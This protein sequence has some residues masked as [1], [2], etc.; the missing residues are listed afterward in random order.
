MSNLLKADLFRVLKSKLTIVMACLCVGFPLLTCLLYFGIDLLAGFLG[1][2]AL[3]GEMFN[4]KLIIAGS[5]SLSNNLG[6]V[7]PIFSSLFICQD[8]SNGT[9]RNKIIIGENRKKIYL[10]HLVTTV[11]FNVAASIVYLIFNVVFSSLFFGYGSAIDG[12]EILYLF[13]FFIT[14]IFTF[15][16]IATVSA[17]FA[18]TLRSVAPTIIFT[19]LVGMGLSVI[20]SLVQLLNIEKVKYIMYLIPT[21]SNTVY[22]STMSLF[23][24]LPSGAALF[25]EGVLSYIIF[26]GLNTL[27]GI[28]IFKKKDLK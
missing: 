8:I 4:G 12:S 13:Y 28:L 20:L 14:G 18:M 9:L 15:A 27:F 17:F 1:E 26:G 16:Y 23:G 7:I 2:G 21:F 25:I 24:P 6:L 10:S 5:F 11:I 22:G 3:T 19:V